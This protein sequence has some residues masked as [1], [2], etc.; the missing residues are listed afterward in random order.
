MTRR[1]RQARKLIQKNFEIIMMENLINNELEKL[2][3]YNNKYEQ[4]EYIHECL[5]SL[6]MSFSLN[7]SR[8]LL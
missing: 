3:L 7:S 5:N 6:S 1:Q 4:N 2:G 8:Y